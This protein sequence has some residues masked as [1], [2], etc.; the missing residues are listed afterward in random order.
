M[1]GGV[2]DTLLALFWRQYQYFVFPLI[3]GV[4][5]FQLLREDLRR[6]DPRDSA[7]AS[8]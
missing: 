7:A 6:C 2:A 3:F 4:W 8:I 1:T 5:G